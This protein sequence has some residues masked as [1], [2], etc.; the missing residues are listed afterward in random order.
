LR[1][2][3]RIFSRLNG[4]VTPDRLVTARLAVSRVENLRPHD[5]H[6]RRRLMLE[7]SSVVRESTTLESENRQNGQYTWVLLV[8]GTC[9]VPT[10]PHLGVL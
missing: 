1:T 4:S 9:L 10:L 6:C 7:P 3:L 5:G 2:P 8:V